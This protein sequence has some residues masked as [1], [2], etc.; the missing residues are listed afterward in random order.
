MRRSV[1]A[2]L[3]VFSFITAKGQKL[4]VFK[5]P[6]SI[7]QR[8]VLDYKKEYDD[9]LKTDQS[10]LTPDEASRFAEMMSYNKANRFTSGN[11]YFGWEELE[12][13]LND[14][15]K[16]ITPEAY[17]NNPRLHVYPTH[18]TDYNAFAIHDG[19]FYFNISLL[20]EVSDEAALAFVLGHEVSHY[21]NKDLKNT[22]KSEIK[23][24][25]EKNR[26]K[27]N[28]DE[29]AKVKEYNR[30]F[31]RA[32]DSTGAI[33][34]SGAGYDIRFAI[35]NFY[36]FLDLDE[37]NKM[38]K[39]DDKSIRNVRAAEGVL[40]IDS[41]QSI[42][43]QVMSSHPSNLERIGYF[44]KFI[45]DYNKAGNKKFQVGTEQQFKTLQ[46]KARLESLN[47][48][49]MDYSYRECAKRAFI[50]HLYEP[51]ND[52]YIYFL[53]ES[54]RRLFF[55]EPNITDKP[56][57]TETLRKGIFKPE[58]GILHNLHAL[59]RD[60]VSYKTLPFSACQDS[61]FIEFET[62]DEAFNY[63][64]DLALEK[65]YPE[66]YLTIALR[67]TDTIPLRDQYLK[68][69]IENKNARYY[70][71]AA[72][73][74]ADS[75]VEAVKN[76][77]R[78]VVIFD[79]ITFLEDHKYGYHNRYLKA[80]QESGKYENAL[81]RLMTAQ[82]PKREL[83]LYQ[84]NLIEKFDETVTYRDLFVSGAIL[85]LLNVDRRKSNRY[86]DKSSTMQGDEYAKNLFLF[87]PDIWTFMTEEKLKTLEWISAT[88]YED[89]QKAGAFIR[90]LFKVLTLNLINSSGSSQYAYRVKYFAFRP[91]SK[92]D[93]KILYSDPFVSYKF[94]RSNF[95]NTVYHSLRNL[96]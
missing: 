11:L 68:L 62:W 10:G 58:E 3:L 24:Q 79:D 48:L 92:T 35:F 47:S 27:D 50:Y 82:F 87:N 33:L 55:I 31:E 13:Y 28:H 6:K 19:T 32:A 25:T 65:K 73:L 90:K 54:T 78:E 71:Y 52:D 57:L 96:N 14:V 86:E 44:N 4:D 69:Y 26:N 16:K 74:L 22:F 81:S 66:V 85:Q 61:K 94:T 7:P 75:L 20:A 89:N 91:F 2:L 53:L 37:E 23:L 95:K 39:K 83:V 34:V 18:E 72:S 70:K 93:Q 12:N 21:I 9:F 41:L 43:E 59:I 64:A 29:W 88:S 46:R 51:D 38:N 63:F 56:F 80:Y 40:D 30:S 15:L 49:M 36:K 5:N 60:S 17:R 45:Q 76:N 84:R 1:V 42:E 67:N 77:S 8:Y